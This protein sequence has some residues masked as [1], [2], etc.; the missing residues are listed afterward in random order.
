MTPIKRVR[1]TD[2]IG[3][4]ER[5]LW[6]GRSESGKTYNCLSLRL[7]M[8]IPIDAEFR[9]VLELATA[10]IVALGRSE[11]DV[12]TA[13][14]EDVSKLSEQGRYYIFYVTPH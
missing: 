2:V 3:E 8:M 9:K 14:E 7:L 10:Q 4:G 12:R 13:G 1:W 6:Q 5:E 11:V